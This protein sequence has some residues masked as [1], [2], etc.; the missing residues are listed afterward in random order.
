[1]AVN[2]PPLIEP[3]ELREALLRLL[4]GSDSD[5]AIAT[6]LLIV[7]HGLVRQS[8]GAVR[9]NVVTPLPPSVP[10]PTGHN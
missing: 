8:N 5:A 2:C 10:F 1:V 9:W 7:E 6:A 3:E 4:Q